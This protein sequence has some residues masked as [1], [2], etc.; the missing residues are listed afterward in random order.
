LQSKYNGNF[1]A[2]QAN[3]FADMEERGEER[4]ES[5]ALIQ[6]TNKFLT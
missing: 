5:L 1:I 6:A 4:E 2:K 3:I